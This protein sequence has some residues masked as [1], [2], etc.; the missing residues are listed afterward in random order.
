M[1]E[2]LY[3]NLYCRDMHPVAR[4]IKVVKIKPSTTVQDI[5]HVLIIIAITIAYLQS[6][7]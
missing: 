7:S 1:V 4:T 5:Y 2:A 3:Y 6:S